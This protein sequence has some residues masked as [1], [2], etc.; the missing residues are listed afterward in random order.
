VVAQLALC[1]LL[2]TGAGLASR[3]VYLI[4]QQDLH[5]AKDH[6]LLAGIDTGGAAT[7]QDNIA[8]LDRLRQRL[9]AVPGIVSVSYATAV[10]S[11]NFGGW[12]DSVQAVGAAQ[13]VH[14]NGMYTGPGYLETLRVRGLQGRGIT[15]EDV[16]A[17]RRSA[18]IN[19]NLAQA[20]WP[21]QS[22]LGRELLVFNEPVTVVGVAPNTQSQ[23]GTNY[24]FLPDRAGAAGSRVIYLRYSGSLDAIGSAVRQAIREVDTHIPVASLRT[25]ERELEDDNGPTILIASLLGIFSTAALIL[26]AIGLYAVVALQTARRRRDFGIRMALGASSRQILGTVLREGLLLAAIGGFCGLALSVAAGKHSAAY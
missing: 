18:V 7:A 14:A 4:G 20:L 26:A 1:C 22:A 15:A 10:L 2:L 6:L 16:T 8:L 25:M 23:P 17:A 5:F 21:G 12:S 24:V 9:R 11:S 19:R 3:S 13:S